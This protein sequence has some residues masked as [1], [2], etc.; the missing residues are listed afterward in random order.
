M[1]NI[2]VYMKVSLDNFKKE[3]LVYEIIVTYVD[4]WMSL[5]SHD[6]KCNNQQQNHSNFQTSEKGLTL[7]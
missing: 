4:G 7:H 3:T 6:Y 5:P 1:K 2:C